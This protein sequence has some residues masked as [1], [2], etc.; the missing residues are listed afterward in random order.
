M[1]GEY[2]QEI[3][4]NL[5]VDIWPKEGQGFERHNNKGDLK[6][7]RRVSSPPPSDYFGL[8]ESK[9]IHGPAKTNF[10]HPLNN[11]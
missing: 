5:D 4:N 7:S 2:N 3:V 11:P 10:N 9:N 8:L 1:W 6:L